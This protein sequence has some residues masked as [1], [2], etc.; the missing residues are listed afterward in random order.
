MNQLFDKDP[1]RY[2]LNLAYRHAMDPAQKGKERHDLEAAIL[3]GGYDYDKI[4]E[5][6][7][8]MAIPYGVDEA[9]DRKMLFDTVTSN[10]SQLEKF[11]KF[12]HI[13]PKKQAPVATNEITEALKMVNYLKREGHLRLKDNMWKLRNGTAFPDL[14]TQEGNEDEA[15]Y[16]LAEFLI[17]DAKMMEKVKTEYDRVTAKEAEP[18]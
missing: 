5:L 6:C 3:F 10:K 2:V 8:V 15:P 1:L 11:K 16:T 7:D 9:V 4:K 14:H 17:K 13:E 12:A 18:A